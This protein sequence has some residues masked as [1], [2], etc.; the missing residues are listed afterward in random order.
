MTRLWSGC[1]RFVYNFKSWNPK[2]LY[3]TSLVEYYPANPASNLRLHNLQA[4]AL[5]DVRRVSDPN[6]EQERFISGS[7]T[8]SRLLTFRPPERRSLLPFHNGPCHDSGRS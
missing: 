5:L 1:S 2:G 6:L 4:T 8:R 7:R 3:R